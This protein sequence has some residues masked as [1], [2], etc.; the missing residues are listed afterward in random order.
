MSETQQPSI[1]LDNALSGPKFQVNDQVLFRQIESEAVLLHI[2]NGSY[3]S[4]NNTSLPFWEAIRDQ[5]PLTEAVDAIINDYEV[6]REQV[7]SDLQI[8][9]A[10]MLQYELISEA[11]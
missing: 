10:Q 4:L 1:N 6:E 3:Y 2:S 8:F 11:A 9:L 5:V 7:L